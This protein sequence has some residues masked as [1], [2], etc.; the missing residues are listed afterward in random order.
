MLRKSRLL[1]NKTVHST[2]ATLTT[3]SDDGSDAREQRPHTDRAPM[4]FKL[5]D[6]V[7]DLSCR[8]SHLM[9]T[10]REQI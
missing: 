5:S 4:V 8:C 7:H 1:L 2:D 10:R 9:R 6:I 3:S